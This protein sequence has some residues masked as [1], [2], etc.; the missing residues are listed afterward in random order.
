MT[1][2]LKRMR[3][4]RPPVV[5]LAALREEVEGLAAGLTLSS[6]SSPRLSIWEGS[7][8]G[9]LVMVVLS[10][11]GKVAA[12]MATQFTCDQLG[13]E[14]LLTIGLAG[15]VHSQMEPGRLIVASGAVQY[16]YDARPIAARR[17]E[18]PGL[19][20]L[21]F[22]A[23]ESL[24]VRLLAAARSAVE[25][26]ALVGTGLVLTGDQI[27]AARDVR[28]GIL[29]DFPEGACFDMETAA[30]A[31]VAIGNG[32][33]WGGIRITSDAADES[34]DMSEVLGFGATTAAALFNRIVR[35]F[36]AA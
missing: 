20:E 36:L 28:D 11:V 29:R 9:T 35:A 6:R 34:F 13:P 33:A 3:H 8:E 31:Q 16:D 25:Q 26:K 18:M 23:D 10:G 27:I 19:G 5:V 22:P 21:A 32:V 12:A 17:G 4:A 2:K 15:C 24:C 14:C 30:V 1:V 7:L